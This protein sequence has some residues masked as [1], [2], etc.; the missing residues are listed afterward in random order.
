MYGANEPSQPN[1]PKTETNVRHPQRICGHSAKSE[2]WRPK[3]EQST[4]HLTFS[5]PRSVT[6][7][8]QHESGRLAPFA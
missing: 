2:R 3:G 6:A 4:L 7:K 1:D 8:E 5:V